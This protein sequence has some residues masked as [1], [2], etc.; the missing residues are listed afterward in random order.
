MVWGENEFFEPH[1]NGTKHVVWRAGNS[2]FD[3]PQV[4]SYQQTEWWRTD[5]LPETLRLPSGHDGSHTFI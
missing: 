4:E 1:P 3:S 2:L 5:M